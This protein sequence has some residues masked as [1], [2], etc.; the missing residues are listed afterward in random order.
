[1]HLSEICVNKEDVFSHKM[2]RLDIMIPI[3][4]Q[5]GLRFVRLTIM[6]MMEKITVMYEQE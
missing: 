4:D 6:T 2:G 1:M 5:L 3:A